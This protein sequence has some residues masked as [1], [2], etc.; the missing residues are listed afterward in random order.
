MAHSQ[1]DTRHLFAWL[2]KYHYEHNFYECLPHVA[3]G[4]VKVDGRPVEEGAENKLTKGVLIVADG[5]RLVKALM[6]KKIIINRVS[7]EFE[8]VAS[9]NS[10]VPCLD[11]NDDGAFVYDGAN[12]SMAAVRF[13]NSTSPLLEA[14]KRTSS[15]IPSDFV[16][17]DGRKLSEEDLDQKIGTKTDLAIHIPA[18]YGKNDWP[19]R[20]YI[21]KTSGYGSLGIGKVAQFG[22]EGLEREIYFDYNHEEAQF[23]SRFKAYRT[24]RD[25]F[26]NSALVKIDDQK[27]YLSRPVLLREVA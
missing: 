25:P 13:A 24:E 20:S 22:P 26:N 4:R 7:P 10:L 9:Y 17:S 1:N 2:L 27:Q 12:D 21:L 8:P 19:I 16:Y 5:P 6:S 15:L 18:A 14:R 11:K 3:D 23:F